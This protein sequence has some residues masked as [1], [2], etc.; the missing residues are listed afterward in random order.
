MLAFSP[1]AF[2]KVTSATSITLKEGFYSQDFTTNKRNK[3]AIYLKSFK[4]VKEGVADGAQNFA[5]ISNTAYIRFFVK[6][7]RSMEL[8]IYLMNGWGQQTTKTIYVT[9]ASQEGV[10]T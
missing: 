3:T 2:C 10:Y 4:G 8:N 5:S 1:A 6:V 9:K 7:P